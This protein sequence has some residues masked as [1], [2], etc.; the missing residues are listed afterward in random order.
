MPK[1]TNSV[2]A[3]VP[4]YNAAHTLR[5]L[6]AQLTE[7]LDAFYTWQIVLVDD[8]STDESADIIRELCSGDGRITGVLLAENAGQQSAVF[9]GLGFSDCDYAVIIDDDLEQPPRDIMA[10]YNEITKG[11]DVVYGLNAAPPKKGALRRFGSAMRD[12]LF[13]AVTHLPRD[14]KV[15]AFRILNSA[16]V[17]H[18]LLA[19]T[20]FVYI[21]MEI[22]RHTQKIGNI[23][24]PYNDAAPSGYGLL[25]L[26]RLLIKMYVYY[27]PRTMFKRCRKKGPCYR[28]KKTLHKE[29][30]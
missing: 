1:I 24:V 21:S 17:N 12:G 6:T 22:L 20:Q 14:K 9:C 30:P 16:T 10:L 11:Y 5:S 15:C 3:V 26:M 27:A 4:V 28:I 29:N 7:V 23:Y 8:C 18:V 2:C 25:R 13:Y 19:D